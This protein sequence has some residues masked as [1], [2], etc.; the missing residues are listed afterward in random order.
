VNSSRHFHLLDQDQ[1]GGAKLG[2]RRRMASITSDRWNKNLPSNFFTCTGGDLEAYMPCTPEQQALDQAES[3]AFMRNF[4]ASLGMRAQTLERA[5]QQTREPPLAVHQ[6]RAQ[7][8][9]AQPTEVKRRPGR[10]RRK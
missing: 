5:I 10:P 6:T 7:P 1:A 8:A 2:S 3:A 9:P 4:Y